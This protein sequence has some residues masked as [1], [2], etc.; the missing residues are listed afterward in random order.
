M[1]YIE[2]KLWKAGLLLLVVFV[3]GVYRGFTGQPL[4]PGPRD[5]A[6]QPPEGRQTGR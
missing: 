5:T 1:D 2:F 6:E 3:W 4:Q